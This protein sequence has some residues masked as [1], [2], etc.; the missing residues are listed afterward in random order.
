MESSQTVVKN[1]EE[2]KKEVATPASDTTPS[3]VTTPSSITQIDVT[4]V[5]PSGV[6]V[7][8]VASESATQTGITASG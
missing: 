6:T 7:F 1:S 3:V 8:T 5:A 4:T 2:A